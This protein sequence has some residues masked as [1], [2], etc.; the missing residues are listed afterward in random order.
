[1]PRV[2][3]SVFPPLRNE[4]EALGAKWDSIN[5][6]WYVPDGVDPAPFEKWFILPAP[7]FNIRSTNFS[8][9]VRK[10]N[11]RWCSSLTD[12]ATIVLSPGWEIWGTVDVI[13]E[14]EGSEEELIMGWIQQRIT[15]AVHYIKSISDTALS[16]VQSTV[17]EYKFGLIN[18]HRFRKL[19]N[20]CRFCGS[21]QDKLAVPLN[22]EKTG[23]LA[24]GITLQDHDLPFDCSSGF[25][26]DLLGYGFD[27]F[28]PQ[29]R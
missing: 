3:L 1:M 8:V 10:Q 11:C 26:S 23:R 6:I 13:E 19:F 27:P 2:D 4:A 21:L 9:A 16:A 17:P 14:T 15:A 28:L 7:S 22:D 12:I 25:Q 5:G 24:E 18:G 20:H 29:H